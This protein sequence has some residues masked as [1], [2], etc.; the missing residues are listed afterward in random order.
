MHSKK[1]NVEN[2]KNSLIVISNDRTIFLFEIIVYYYVLEIVPK[3]F[4]FLKY[5]LLILLI[6]KGYKI[7]A[8]IPAICMDQTIYMRYKQM[9]S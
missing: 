8:S 1:I 9:S 2:Y 3:I 6:K 4:F 7:H 5:Q